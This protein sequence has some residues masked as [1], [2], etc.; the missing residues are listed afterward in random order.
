MLHNFANAHRVVIASEQVENA[1]PHRIG[2]RFEA[3][4]ILLRA[5]LRD[6]GR[7]HRS[8]TIGSGAFRVSRHGR[9]QGW[10]IHRQMS[11]NVSPFLRFGGRDGIRTHDLLIANT[12][13]KKDTE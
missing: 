11:M 8:A 4:C 10:P 13:E 5:R 2:K 3:A 12:D 6:P 9:N 1:N 7:L